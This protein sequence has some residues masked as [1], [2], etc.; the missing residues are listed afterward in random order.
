MAEVVER[1]W[2]AI[3][4]EGFEYYWDTSVVAEGGGHP[5]L[6][7]NSLE[8]EWGARTEIEQSV[9][10]LELGYML[11]RLRMD[12]EYSWRRRMD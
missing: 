12:V 7:R 6:F 1:S 2:T 5:V 3:G 11:E 8:P 9:S 10:G 4:T